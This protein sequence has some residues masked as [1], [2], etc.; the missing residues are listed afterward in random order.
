MDWASASLDIVT[1]LSIDRPHKLMNKFYGPE[2]PDFE[3]VRDLFRE[4]L[5]EVRNGPIERAYKWICDTCYT[6]DRLKIERLSGDFLPMEHC[7]INLAIVESRDQK[8][9]RA[10]EEGSHRSSPFSVD[11]RIEM[12]KPDVEE[13]PV[14]LSELFMQRKDAKGGRFTLPRR[15]FIRGRAGVGK[16]TLCKKIV[17]ESIY[18]G[19]WGDMFD[20][21]LW[22]PLRNSKHTS[23]TPQD[24]FF[25][26]YFSQHAQGKQLAEEF[27]KALTATHSNRTLFLLDGLDE[28]SELF[29]SDSE[30]QV[31]Q[32]LRTLLNQPNVI[33]T[34]RPHA[35]L[36]PDITRPDLELDA[37]GFYGDQ[38]EAYT[39]MAFTGQTT[40][41]TDSKR[42]DQILSF[43]DKHRIIQSL[44]R[45]PVQL[46]ALCSTWDDDSD[47]SPNTMT[48]LYHM[49][50]SKLW[51]KDIRRL[52]KAKAGQMRNRRVSGE[53]MP[54]VSK[55]RELVEAL[56]FYGIL[57]DVSDFKKASR[58]LV[59]KAVQ[60]DSAN[61]YVD[62][63]MGGDDILAKVSFLRTSDDSMKERSYHFLH[64][65]FHEYF[66]ARYF[67]RRWEEERPFVLLHTRSNQ[68]IIEPVRFLVEHIYD[69]R[70]DIF[71]RFVTG[72]LDPEKQHIA[73][74]F[75]VVQEDTQDLLG[76]AH[77][78]LMMRLWGEVRPVQGPKDQLKTAWEKELSR[79]LLL[80]H[81][82]KVTSQLVAQ[83]G[84]PETILQEAHN[85]ATEEQAKELMK[86]A[87]TRR[88]R[89]NYHEVRQRRMDPWEAST[90]IP[91][92][93]ILSNDALQSLASQLSNN[94]EGP[95]ELCQAMERLRKHPDLPDDIV[96][97]L[98][99]RFED[100]YE[101]ER[102]RSDAIAVLYERQSLPQKVLLSLAALF[103]DPDE[104]VSLGAQRALRSQAR[105]PDQVVK[106]IA[107]WLKDDAAYIRE[108]AAYSLGRQTDLPEIVLWSLTQ[109][110]NGTDGF[111]D[112]EVIDVLEG[113][114][115]LPDR[116]LQYLVERLE[117]RDE[118]WYAKK[119]MLVLLN[120]QP[121]AHLPDGVVESLLKSLAAQLDDV[122]D[123][124]E[125][126]V[127][128]CLLNQRALPFD[129]IK[130]H[131]RSFLRLL[132]KHSLEMNITWTPLK[133]ESCIHFRSRTIH[134]QGDQNFGA[135]QQFRDSL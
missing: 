4:I 39:K 25:R 112:D 57:N 43:L 133:A 132:L 79:W 66:A 88:Y 13:I 38:V 91:E 114:L 102:V 71:W 126:L 2:D 48:Q 76:P 51:K 75:K 130:L 16:T 29:E 72:L 125:S 63:G 59:Y 12:G 86:R 77:Q 56:A 52:E 94:D 127:I 93:T 85:H 108:G 104:W 65:T 32:L 10:G 129:A 44:V 74:F 55:E 92:I 14:G 41:D 101:N 131:L 45:I 78:S 123:F 24:L 100:R 117:D 11:T 69:G 111:V 81:K 34:S 87:Q 53:F 3:K 36:R 5:D 105:L 46:D 121:L 30:G 9:K 106:S 7:Y 26:E 98:Q 62:T 68:K 6:K 120:R 40:G 70:Y 109:Q 83:D 37:V 47:T 110:L 50:E 113:Q 60:R 1:P 89:M 27:Y 58:D 95:H 19:M 54:L 49:V 18:H 73:R 67:V 22:I 64:L 99:A 17:H 20:L 28:V 35:M 33:I 97:L 122:P 84:L 21:I 61:S 135:I 124:A 116:L 119:S 82:L 128:E 96:S 118:S 115:S 42:I 31:P 90:R 8:Q 23:G 15:I 80:E 107:K 134:V 103:G